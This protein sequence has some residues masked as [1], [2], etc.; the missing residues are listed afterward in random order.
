MATVVIKFYETDF[1][2]LHGSI[3]TYL[4]RD[5]RMYH[6]KVNNSNLIVYFRVLKMEMKKIMI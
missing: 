6:K 1:K 5:N 3:A 2:V 4:S